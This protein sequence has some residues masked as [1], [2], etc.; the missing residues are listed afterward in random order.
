VSVRHEAGA[1]PH[2]GTGVHAGAQ[3]GVPAQVLR[4]SAREETLPY[5]GKL[6]KCT[7]HNNVRIDPARSKSSQ[8]KKWV[9]K[10]GVELW[11][12]ECYIH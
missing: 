10:E 8:N 3:G 9:E 12:V 6:V 1:P 4:S 5:Q 7:V 2:P 11:R